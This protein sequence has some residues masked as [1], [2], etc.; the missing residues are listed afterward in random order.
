MS[1]KLASKQK[2]DISLERFW[3]VWKVYG[4]SRKF[5]DS[6]QSFWTLWKGSGQSG[7]VP[8][9]L[10]S[11]RAV[12][13]VSKLFRKFPESLESFRTVWKFSGHWIVFFGRFQTVLSDSH[14]FVYVVKT[15]YA[16]LAHMSWKKLR[17]SSGKFLLV[18]ICRPE[19]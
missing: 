1:S 15:I 6:L 19:S 17:A 4:Q 14:T 8:D 3:T 11:F 9:S 18:K 5:L 2:E 13:K 7:K 16:L 12:W 10:I